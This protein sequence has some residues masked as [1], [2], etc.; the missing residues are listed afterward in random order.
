MSQWFKAFSILAEGWVQFPAPIPDSSLSSVNPVPEEPMPSSRFYGNCAHDTHIYTNKIL[1]TTFLFKKIIII[2]SVNKDYASVSIQFL[3]KALK[4]A[5]HWCF[6]L[7]TSP[8]LIS[9]SFLNKSTFSWLTPCP[10][11]S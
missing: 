10:N 5:A 11:S 8:G 3:P 2:T 6:S 4:R 9:F 7:V 1:V